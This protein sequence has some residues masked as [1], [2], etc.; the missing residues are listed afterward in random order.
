M[1]DHLYG[2]VIRTKIPES[3][4][5]CFADGTPVSFDYISFHCCNG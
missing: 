1:R 4:T 3:A 2:Q 5:A